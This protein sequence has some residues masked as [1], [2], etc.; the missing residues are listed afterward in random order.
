MNHPMPQAG[1]DHQ[2]RTLPGPVQTFGL[3]IRPDPPGSLLEEE[4]HS[5]LDLFGD[6]YRPGKRL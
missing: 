2:L 5:L 4:G 1:G 6:T 3:Q